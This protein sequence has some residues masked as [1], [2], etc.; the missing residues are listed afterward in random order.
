MDNLTLDQPVALPNLT[1]TPQ[2][3]TSSP[4]LSPTSFPESAEHLLPETSS[5]AHPYT[6]SQNLSSDDIRSD[7]ILSKMAKQQGLMPLSPPSTLG[8][9]AK[10]AP[11]GMRDKVGPR[12]SKAAALR[13]GVEWEGRR[14]GEGERRPVDFGNTPG[15][16]RNNLS[17]VSGGG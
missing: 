11:T 10:P 17:L 12:M 15:H 9:K 2:T 14:A 8:F 16:K 3:A 5:V 1:T 7:P 4:L 6:D 13:I